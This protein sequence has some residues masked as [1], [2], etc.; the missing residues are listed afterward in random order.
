MDFVKTVEASAYAE[1][2]GWGPS[3]IP[4]HTLA[5]DKVASCGF[6]SE[7]MT[8]F[9]DG[10]RPRQDGNYILLT[11]LGA[12]EYFGSNKNGDFFNE[13][14]IKGDQ[15]PEWI[16]KLTNE[17]NLR[18]PMEYGIQTFLKHGGI[19]YHHQNGD[20]TK[21]IGDVCFADYNVLMHRGE[22][23]IFIKKMLAPDIIRDLLNGIPIPWSMGAKLSFDVCVPPWTRI[24]TERGV[25]RADEVLPTDKLWT[26][27]GRFRAITKSFL[28][29][30]DSLTVLKAT[31]LVDPLE[32]TPSHSVEVVRDEEFRCDKKAGLANGKNRPHK[33][34]DGN[35]KTCG[36]PEKYSSD[37]TE[38]QSVR[39]G[40]WLVHHLDTQ[41]SDVGI[42]RSLGRILGLYAAEGSLLHSSYE[43]KDGTRQLNGIQLAFNLNEREWVEPLLKELCAGLGI[44]A[45]LFYEHPEKSYLQ[46]HIQNN[47]VAGMCASHVGR[48]REKRLSLTLLHLPLDVQ[49]E[50]LTGWMDG[51]GSQDLKCGGMRGIS[52]CQ[53]LAEGMRTLAWRSGIPA[54]LSKW[55]DVTTSFGYVGDVFVVQVSKSIQDPIVELSSRFSLPDKQYR[56]RGEV[57]ID[58]DRVLLQ[59]R[60]VSEIPY[61]GEVYNWSVEEDETY[62]A[63]GFSVHN[64]SIC[65]HAARNRAQYC[66]HAK[67]SLNKILDNGQKVFVY[68]P[69]P[70][71]FDISKVTIPADRSAWILQKV[72]Q[73]GLLLP[74]PPSRKVAAEKAADIIKR[75]DEGEQKDLG[76][77]P[78]SPDMWNRL[79]AVVICDNNSSSDLPDPTIDALGK[80]PLESALSAVTRA[81][82]VL[83][84]VEAS[85]V[86]GGRE[87]PSAINV[88]SPDATALRLL[89]GVLGSAARERSMFEPHFSRRVTLI[90]ARKPSLPDPK[91]HVKKASAD[92]GYRRYLEIL[93]GTDLDDL[94]GS[95]DDPKLVLA[96]TDGVARTTL[97]ATSEWT[98]WPL[99]AAITLLQG[100]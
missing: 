24:R 26:H 75:I 63:A 20:R 64:C 54:V 39:E 90:I 61:D 86:I 82:I 8:R 52:V 40:D 100:R 79:R 13:W 32:V 2:E 25:V 46:V 14:S 9:V 70:V 33:F 37:F 5:F 48:A 95:L 72:A 35:C 3:A 7:R 17:K 30:A 57:V 43:R 45:P 27:E 73:Q 93:S 89:S 99:L 36:E 69:Y 78:I 1:M 87:L 59:V 21:S 65:L 62:E 47:W 19:Y 6:M 34:E 76:H 42:T 15:P 74:S 85:R 12:G 96:S 80:A 29:D 38:A 66:S 71:F 81:G 91:K 92:P 23:V 55:A 31:G 58:G 97:G 67:Y 83:R 53:D 84:P 51:D 88:A 16:R 10:C 50:I 22:L 77:S 60:K 44:N 94:R 49:M 56:K 18:R 41:E 28:R 4:L 98:P 11:A 68:N